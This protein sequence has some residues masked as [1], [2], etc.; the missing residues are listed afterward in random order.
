L[1]G[2]K[3]R[4]ALITGAARG[5]GLAT[6]ERFAAEG[7]FVVGID[8][9]LEGLE[10]Q[11]QIRWIEADVA[12]SEEMGAAAQTAIDATG[13]LDVCIANAGIN[14][15]E[16]FLVGSPNSWQEVLSVNLIGVMVTLQAAARQMVAEGKGGRL[17]ATAS[18]A[19]IHG[20]PETPAYCASKGG[21]IALMQ[22][23]AVELGPYGITANAVAPGQIDTEMNARD[24]AVFSAR[25]GRDVDE[26][27]DEFLAGNVPARRLG[28]PAEVAAVFA[29]LASD[30]APFVNGETVRIDGGELAV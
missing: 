29:F 16:E 4:T 21:V 20:E 10:S 27:R 13:G 30:E 12:N 9:S 18:I 2:L 28:E 14:R 6:V 23:L 22:A 25:E 7:A 8:R 11:E 1:R 26:F 5:I 24:S 3:D 15:V 17:L 19:G